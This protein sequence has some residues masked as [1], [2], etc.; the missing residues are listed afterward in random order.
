MSAIDDYLA[1]VTP[2]EKEA[3]ERVRTIVADAAPGADEGKSYGMPAFRVH[4][5]VVAGFVG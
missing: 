1:T 4:G 5:G 3:L 2:A